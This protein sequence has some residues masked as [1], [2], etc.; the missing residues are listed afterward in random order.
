MV[1]SDITVWKLNTA[2]GSYKIICEDFF[3]LCKGITD[4]LSI[5]WLIASWKRR[6]CSGLEVRVGCLATENW[7]SQKITCR[8]MFALLLHVL[9]YV[10]NVFN[11][12]M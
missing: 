6:A 4:K 5:L 7:M 11:I 1:S 12:P 8:V 9:E 10:L 2:E 3:Y